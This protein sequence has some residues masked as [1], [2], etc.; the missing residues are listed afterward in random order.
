MKKK[1]PPKPEFAL[2]AVFLSPVSGP[3]FMPSIFQLPKGWRVKWRNKRGEMH[4]E[5]CPTYAYAHMYAAWV[6]EQRQFKVHHCEA[7]P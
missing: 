5:D 2:P 4:D 1:P 3:L 6:A 7:S